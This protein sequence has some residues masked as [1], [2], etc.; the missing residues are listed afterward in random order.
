MALTRRELLVSSGAAALAASMPLWLSRAAHGSPA[1]EPLLALIFLRGGA[2]GLDLVPPVGDPGLE[3][4]RGRFA[5]GDARP[6]AAGF[7]LHPA[8]A[9]LDPVVARGQLGVVHA[10]GAPRASRSHFEAQ[11]A[12]ESG[13]DGARRL[14]DG[15]LARALGPVMPDDPLSSVS[16][17]LRPTPSLAGAG[18][19]AV[20]APRALALRG[21]SPAA[22]S[23]LGSL[24][25]RGDDHVRRAGRRALD[26][27]GAI[28][29]R[30]SGSARPR[31][32][33]AALARQIDTLEALE[34]AGLRVRAAALELDG[35]DH[36]ARQRAP[37]AMARLAAELA[38]GV[39]RLLDRDRDV[40]VVAMTEFGRTVAPNGSG[41]TD[42]GHGAAILVAGPRVRGGVHGP[43]P[44]LSRERLHEGRDLAV[45]TDYRDV[46]Y[47][48]LRAHLGRA[49]GAAVFPGH[50]PRAVGLIV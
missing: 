9:A 15:W 40:L 17:G 12:V 28:R 50:E 8:M 11:D 27:E 39:A 31:R 36:H 46:L 20:P 44:G 29:A 22:R 2:D 32:G 10:V 41:G 38:V 34:R 5:V 25:A 42:H 23:A 21:A 3:R 24:Y 19:F 18:A 45:A 14:R 49:P 43:W 30:V 13:S 37:G 6:L 48:V 26:V 47:E 1:G 33:P 4:L 16:L 35:W 7:G